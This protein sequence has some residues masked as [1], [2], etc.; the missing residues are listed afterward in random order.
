[1]LLQS[2]EEQDSAIICFLNLDVGNPWRTATDLR[3]PGCSGRLAVNKPERPINVADCSL[4]YQNNHARAA[5][6]LNVFLLTLRL[7]YSQSQNTRK[8]QRAG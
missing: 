7:G 6:R 8:S 2:F 4:L 5:D 3:V 1:M